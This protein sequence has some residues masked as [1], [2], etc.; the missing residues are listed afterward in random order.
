MEVS[1]ADF[2]VLVG[3]KALEHVV[4]V[5]YVDLDCVILYV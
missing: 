5:H 2:A 4:E 3:L 1:P